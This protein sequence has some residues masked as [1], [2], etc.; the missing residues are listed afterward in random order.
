MPYLRMI[1]VG[2]KDFMLKSDLQIFELSPP[3]RFVC[4]INYSCDKMA[5]SIVRKKKI[6]VEM[7][8]DFL[9]MSY[10]FEMSISMYVI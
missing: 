1:S 8:H 5:K 6:H 10:L 7:S 9:R 4:M 2:F 3:M